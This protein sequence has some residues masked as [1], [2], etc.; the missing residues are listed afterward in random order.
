MQTEFCTSKY[1]RNG[2]NWIGVG[3]AIGAAVFAATNEPVLIALGVAI[4]AAVGWQKQINKIEK[5]G[6]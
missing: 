5:E 2:G 6:S 4:G 1:R 3:T